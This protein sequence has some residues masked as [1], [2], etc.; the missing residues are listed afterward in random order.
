MWR[1]RAAALIA[2]FLPGDGER[3]GAVRRA[4]AAHAAGGTAM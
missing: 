2:G 3:G 4:L 1:Q